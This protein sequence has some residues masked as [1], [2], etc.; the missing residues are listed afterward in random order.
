[1]RREDRYSLSA[2]ETRETFSPEQREAGI[3]E[4]G[5]FLFY[6]LKVQ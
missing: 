2:A 3:V 4:N 6:V 1:L 5:A